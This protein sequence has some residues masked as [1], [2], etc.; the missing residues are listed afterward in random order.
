MRIRSG[1]PPTPRSDG[2]GSAPPR[3]AAPRWPRA[4][5]RGAAARPRPA[6][7][8]P[9]VTRSAR[10]R[11]SSGTSNTT[12]ATGRPPRRPHASSGRR[13]PSVRLVASTTVVRPRARRARTM[14][15][16]SRKASP[17]AALIGRV[18]GDDRAQRIRGHDLGGREARRRPRALARAGR[19]HEQHQGAGDD[20]GGWV[21]HGVAGY[22]AR[23]VRGDPAGRPM[24][25]PRRLG[26]D[27]LDDPSLS[28]PRGPAR[29]AAR[30]AGAGGRRLGG[31]GGAPTAIPPARRWVRRRDRGAHPGPA[32]RRTGAPAPA[33][34]S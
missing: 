2:R 22:R 31:A 3:A 29:A 30:V 4:A 23:A 5:A 13:A 18:V 21:D 26:D 16:S 25:V 19:S 32:R 33:A 7:S 6:P 28:S 17:V 34:T 14:A 11:S 15:C 1:R 24:A 8:A 20:G 9:R 10:G 12:A 27:T